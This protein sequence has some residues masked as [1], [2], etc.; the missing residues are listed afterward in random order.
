MLT[1]FVRGYYYPD[2]GGF[3]VSW[4]LQ[5]GGVISAIEWRGPRDLEVGRGQIAYFP[6]GRIVASLSRY[7]SSTAISIYDVV[8]GVHMHD[9]DHLARP[10]PDPD[11]RAPYMYK[12]WTHGESL[13]F[14]TPESTGITIWDVGLAPGAIP[15][16]VEKVTSP[17]TT[18]APKP[19]HQSDLLWSEFHPASSRLAFIRND[20]KAPLRVWDSQASK[21]LLRYD[22][23]LLHHDEGVITFDP[24]MTFSSDGRFFACGTLGPNVFLWRE[25]PTG[26]TL[27]ER[28]TSGT[29]H[30]N[31]LLSPNGESIILFGSSKIQSWHIKSFTA[32]NPARALRPT[33]ENFILEFFPDRPLAVAT[34]K[35]DRVVAV[36]DLNSGAPLLTI[37]TSIPV[38]GLRPIGKSI[39]VIGEKKAIVWDLPG[40]NF[41]P[42]ARM[43]IGDSTSTIA[44]HNEDGNTVFS[45]S[46]SLDFQYIALVGASS[47]GSFLD[48]HC[49]STGQKVHRETLSYRLWF[50]PGDHDIWC[51]S[52]GEAKVFTL[53]QHSLDHTKTISSSEY[54]F[55]GCPWGSSLGHEVTDDR[56]IVG[57]DGKRL[58]MLP[59]LWY[60]EH[61]LDRLWNGK[62]FALLHGDLAGPVVLELEP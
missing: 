12:I 61:K 31:P 53:I 46:I 27:L 9:V 11:L 35:G 15:T 17:D 38:C 41:L 7:S 56:W 19:R 16:E 45:A 8:S 10:N 4:D 32:S 34:R 39:V 30:P 1:S 52:T 62:F 5:T 55:W 57:M 2:T 24:S 54:E 42:N 21:S 51:A 36:L 48:V 49:I 6:N 60:T 44:F 14:A 13:R 43:K 3:V 18:L 59:P 23:S 50:A 29:Q 33:K 22:A 26:Y 20:I 58:L 25:S 40:G 47:K 28:L 37:D